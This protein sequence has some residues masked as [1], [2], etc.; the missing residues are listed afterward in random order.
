MEE[1]NSTTDQNSF[2]TL[3]P[4]EGESLNMSWLNHIFIERLFL[5][6]D[7]PEFKYNVDKALERGLISSLSVASHITAIF[8]QQEEYQ[9]GKVLEYQTVTSSTALRWLLISYGSSSTRKFFVNMCMDVAK[10]VDG[11]MKT[12]PGR[13]VYVQDDQLHAQ[14]ITAK[15][16]IEKVKKYA[17]VLNYW[18]RIAEEQLKFDQRWG[19]SKKWVLHG[20]GWGH[21]ENIWATGV[22]ERLAKNLQEAKSKI[23]MKLME[24]GQNPDYSLQYVNLLRDAGVADG[25]EPERLVF[26]PQTGRLEWVYPTQEP[27]ISKVAGEKIRLSA[28]LFLDGIS[29]RCQVAAAQETA[30]HLKPKSLPIEQD[31]LDQHP[32]PRILINGISDHQDVSS[33]ELPDCYATT[34]SEAASQ[35]RVGI[36]PVKQDTAQQVLPGLPS[37]DQ[38]S[39]NIVPRV[40]TNMFATDWEDTTPVVPGKSTTWYWGREP[41]PIGHDNVPYELGDSRFWYSA[42]KSPDTP[43]AIEPGVTTPL[44]SLPG[45]KTEK[46]ELASWFGGLGCDVNTLPG[47]KA[48]ITKKEDT[49]DTNSGHITSN[50]RPYIHIDLTDLGERLAIL[51]AAELGAMHERKQ[52]ENRS[53]AEQTL[54]DL[55]RRDTQLLEELQHSVKIKEN[56]LE[57]LDSDTPIASKMDAVGIFL[58]AVEVETEKVQG[59]TEDLRQAEAEIDRGY[60]GD[61]EEELQSEETHKNKEA[62]LRKSAEYPSSSQGENHTQMIE[63]S[64]TR[65]LAKGESIENEKQEAE[66]NVHKGAENTDAGEVMEPAVAQAVGRLSLGDWNDGSVAGSDT[67]VYDGIDPSSSVEDKT[68]KADYTAEEHDVLSPLTGN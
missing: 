63:G 29:R 35:T 58:D 1:N 38:T 2:S 21:L 66:A 53:L 36:P 65:L 30:P 64:S 68:T 59:W 28:G 62:M 67:R 16:W 22:M 17:G 34:G 42:R 11:L 50:N 15:E 56:L 23:A 48:D 10:E 40:K 33:Q 9:L 41:R 19:T 43:N 55:P 3:G 13:S 37:N 27:T 8:G 14:Q 61:W 32:G 18:L 4:V 49:G 39:E 26:W 60:D 47:T 57:K 5:N 45:A 6:T 54:L 25:G 46:N 24:A 31:T 51:D 52:Q 7:Y 12:E 44:S 20:D